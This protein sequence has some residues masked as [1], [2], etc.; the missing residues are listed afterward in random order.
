MRELGAAGRERCLQLQLGRVPDE[1]FERLHDRPVR[2]AHDGIAGAE[3]DEHVLGRERVR[4]FA[5]EPALP[6]SRLA[7]HERRPAPLALRAGQERPQR[8]QLAR[9]SGEGER[10]REAEWTGKRRHD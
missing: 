5:Y 6:R 8:R 3:Q 9:A 4:D 10:R 7:R 2:G 1:A